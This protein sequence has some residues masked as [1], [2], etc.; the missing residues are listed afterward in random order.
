M[1]RAIGPRVTA[2]SL[3]DGPSGTVP[4]PGAGTMQELHARI[5]TLA[6]AQDFLARKRKLTGKM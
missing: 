6:E 3:L 5:G 1:E 4:E 2:R